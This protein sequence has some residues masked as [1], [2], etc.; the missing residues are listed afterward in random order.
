MIYP[1]ELI[2]A[3]HRRAA[4]RKLLQQVESWQRTPSI[5]PHAMDD[6]PHDKS[7]ISA[8]ALDDVF[9]VLTKICTQEEEVVNSYRITKKGSLPND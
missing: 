1:D 8:D 7:K 6:L 2:R 5:I 4:Y 9:D 3:I